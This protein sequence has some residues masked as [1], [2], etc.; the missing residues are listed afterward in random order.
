[1]TWLR[2]CWYQA[3]WSDEL[4]SGQPLARTL[5]DEPILLYRTGD[6]VAALLDR[7]PHRF[8]P[9]SAG[10]VEG[11]EVT[12]GY[13]GLAFGADG[14]CVRNP[15]GA[16]TSRMHVRSYP[17]VERHTALWIWMGA[18]EQA[19]P[20]A[21]P[22]LGFIDATP[23]GAR[24]AGHMPTA[25]DYRLLTDNIMD[26][27]HADYLHP[28]TL[29]GIMTGSKARSRE[30]GARVVAEWVSE[31]CDPIP[32]AAATVPPGAKVDSWTQVTWSAPALMVLSTAT[33]PA[34]V[35]RAPEN[36]AITLHNMVPESARSTHYFFC[37]TRR[38]LV[39]DAGFSAYIRAALSRAFV[40]EDKP[41]IEAQ[42]RRMGE[43]DLWDL[44]PI[45][46]PTDAA[47]VRVRR[48]LDR[49]LAEERARADVQAEPGSRTASA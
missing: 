18:P 44:D 23:S 16:I 37:S 4:G 40:E 30:E 17:V 49:L 39:D 45:L 41:M 25:A 2:N 20:A 21:I 32:A 8:A 38:F 31:N 29:G 47:A 43:A 46:L 11:N 36:E 34:G 24:I 9:L 10:R 26:L 15:H 7:C 5:L 35:P 19:D 3:G 33:T 6:G 1:M 14:V 12:C 22:D 48:L 42:Q 27:S 13:H 28:T